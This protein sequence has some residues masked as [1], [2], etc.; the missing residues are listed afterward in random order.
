MAYDHRKAGF[1]ADEFV[2]ALPER[3]GIRERRSTAHR[4]ILRRAA[5]RPPWPGPR[6][7]RTRSGDT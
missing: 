5:G 7:A 4:Q 6:A 1:P 3:A 2:V